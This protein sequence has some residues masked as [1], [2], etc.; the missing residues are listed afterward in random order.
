[1]EA[2]PRHAR[3]IVEETGCGQKGALRIPASKQQ[4]TEE[5]KVKEEEAI[6]SYRGARVT[7]VAEWE[8]KASKCIRSTNQH[9][10]YL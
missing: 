2:D 3:V 8:R 4:D 6:A 1:M 7:R 9:Y 10:N 5:D